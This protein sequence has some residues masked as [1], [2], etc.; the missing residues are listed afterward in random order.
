M[1]I[2]ALPLPEHFNPDRVGDTWRVPFRQRAVD[3]R[4]WAAHHHLTPADRD[5][6]RIGLLIVDVQN[7]FCLP[8]FELFVAGRSGRGAIE[9]NIRLC[10]FIY[11]YLHLITETVVTLDTHLA[12][13]IFHPLF[14][15][16]AA[17][18]HP[19]PMTVIRTED[20]DTGRWRVNPALSRLKEGWSEERMTRYARHYTR[21]LAEKDKFDLMI[22]PYH[23]MFGGIGHALV[24]AVEEAL[25][26]HTVARYSQTRFEAKGANP[27]TEN[28]SV[29]SPEVL[30]DPD[31]QAIDRVNTALLDRLLAYDRLIIAGQAKSH[32]LA[33]T[34]ADLVTEIQK[35]DPALADRVY[36][37][38]D[39]SSAV[40]IEGV[41]DFTDEAE[42]AFDR[43]AA[44]GM[45]RVTTSQPL[46]T[47]PGF[48][49]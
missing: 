25:F 40:V 28:Y 5:D 35:R 45:H 36:L 34:V 9:D 20:L 30:D 12:A 1:K 27:L 44:A 14:W 29:L 49:L 32:C 21:Q 15:I 19:A 41:V 2:Q 16:D 7:T 46:D 33:F 24:A 11:R 17:G 26:F 3:A 37:L 43:F 13:Q 8:D 4:Q 22:W 6:T 23:A 10:R 42:A 47:W 18:H 39:T 31:G 48:T 38:E